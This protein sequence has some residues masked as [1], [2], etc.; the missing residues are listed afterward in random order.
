M[1]PSSPSASRPLPQPIENTKRVQRRFAPEPTETTARSN[2]PPQSQ[3]PSPADAA[4]RPRHILPLP[5]GS[6]VRSNRR[7]DQHNDT[8]SPAAPT[9]VMPQSG[10][11][12]PQPI[13]STKSASRSR[14]F[15]PQLVE[16]TSRQRKRGDTL[17]AVLDTDKTEYSP[18]EPIHL[19][20][21]L[22]ISSRPPVLPIPPVNS[23]ITSTDRVPQLNES[24]FS[25]ASL[26]KRT[27]LESSDRRHS[28]RRPELPSIASQTEE[29]DESD[30]SSCPSLSTT[31]SAESEENELRKHATRGHG[32]KPTAY[33]LALA[34]QAAEKQLR[35]QAMA[36]YPN[37]H[38]HEPVDHFAIDRE[39]G[40][41]E[42][43]G[44]L[45]RGATY[46]PPVGTESTAISR[47]ESHAGWDAAE[48]RKHKE[49]LER[50]RQEHRDRERSLATNREHSVKESK[51]EHHHH[52]HHHNHHHEH[53]HHEHHHHHKRQPSQA[54]EPATHRKFL[55]GHQKDDQM[56]PMQKAASPP[57]AGQ[58]LK[59]PRCQ[60]PRQTR[61]DVGQHPGAS[62][63]FGTPKSRD[64]S[65]LWTPQDCASRQNSS[66]GLWM[67]VCA[68]SA[69]K[70]AGPAMLQTGLLTPGVE[71]DDPFV[72]I[73]QNPSHQLPLSP[74]TSIG[75][76]KTCCPDEMLNRE[77]VIKED[78]HDEFVTQVYNYLSLGYPAL[79]RKF[80]EELSKITRIPIEKLRQ[81]DQHTNARGYVGAPEGTGCDLR[82]VQE[83]KCGRWTA[84]RAYVTEWAN[85]QPLM[86]SRNGAANEDW[87]ARARKGSWAI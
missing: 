32:R 74:P 11:N 65:G 61:L 40:G 36:A 12:L 25:Y 72:P 42:G 84:L 87:G 49:N 37:E 46:P 15:A 9:P 1:A 28:F 73:S 4:N 38:S 41:E 60:S 82:G 34:A 80:D 68:L 10:T 51:K 64:H 62:V 45:A 86:G 57:M 30:D 48:M 47:R 69:Q 7:S 79:A 67:G 52:G 85:Q 22:P 58:N 21:H 8:A 71:T 44:L 13:E 20:R 3:E 6:S 70:P 5:V 55:G 56:K 35:E 24:R 83:G 63:H 26:S 18:A 59:F 17:P 54:K 39:D 75:S 31:P 14:K 53:G 66:S 81:D 2:R 16:T 76:S 50:E 23:P 27:T 33:L 77:K 19:H 29:S 43:V 78:F